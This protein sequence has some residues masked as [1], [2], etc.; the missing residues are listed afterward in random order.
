MLKCCAVGWHLKQSEGLAGEGGRGE[1]GQTALQRTVCHIQH[2]MLPQGVVCNPLHHHYITDICIVGVP[3]ESSAL[4]EYG[5]QVLLCG[6]QFEGFISSTATSQT[7]PVE[8][9]SCKI[10][11]KIS[12]NILGE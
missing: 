11:I 8:H 9:I 2:R 4:S 7:Q 10:M 1:R 3:T 12:L 5:C 6:S